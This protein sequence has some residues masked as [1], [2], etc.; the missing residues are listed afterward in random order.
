MSIVRM[1][2]AAAMI[3][4]LTAGAANAQ[5]FNLNPTYGTVALRTGFEPDPWVGAVQSG[6]S[7]DARTINQSCTGFIADAPDAR[8][9]YPAGSLPLIISVA[10][11]ADTT[12]VVNGPDGSWYCNDDGGNNM[13]P[14]LRFEHPASGQYDIWIGTYG[15]SALQNAQLN[16]SELT[17][18]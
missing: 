1:L 13:N 14:S 9:Q 11:N 10:S 5:H 2:A 7:I 15:N 8:L 18:Q 6:G 16:I 17:S 3:T 12:L 4:A